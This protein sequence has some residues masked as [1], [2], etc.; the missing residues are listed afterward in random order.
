VALVLV[1]GVLGS[2]VAPG[3][4]A[5]AP[6]ARPTAP[7]ALGWSPLDALGDLLDWL[8]LRGPAATTASSGAPLESG[9]R[10][11]FGF[12]RGNALTQMTGT[13]GLE[14][15]TPTATP[16][17]SLSPG[18]TPQGTATA[19]PEGTAS[20]TPLTIGT[21][22]NPASQIYP[23][24]G[25]LVHGR[26]ELGQLI[27]LT[28]Q[29]TTTPGAT[30]MA[31]GVAARS[32][33]AD[34]CLPN[35]S[36]GVVEDRGSRKVTVQAN[37]AGNQIRS[38]Y[39]LRQRPETGPNPNEQ[40]RNAYVSFTDQ[41]V[42]TQVAPTTYVLNP[43]VAALTFWY[44]AV[45]DQQATDIPLEV[46]DNC[47]IWSSFVGA[48][49]GAQLSCLP[50]ETAPTDTQRNPPYVNGASVG[51]VHTLTGSFT[52]GDTDVSIAGR[53]P[54]PQFTRTYNSNDPRPGAFG[55]G[56]THN[57]AIH[58]ARPTDATLDLILVGPQGR[59]D[60]YVRQ[61]NGTYTRPPAVY[62]QLAANADGTYTAT[63]KDQTT[64]HFNRCGRLDSI[65]DRYLNT[66]NLGYDAAGLL[67][68]IG[69]P[70][71]R[72]SL[73]LNY[74]GNSQ[75]VSVADWLASGARTVGY[76]YD[77][78]RRLLSVT[79]RENATTTFAYDGT[80]ARLTT[81]TNANSHVVA[82]NTYDSSGRVTAQEPALPPGWPVGQPNPRRSSFSYTRSDG[83]DV[84]LPNSSWQPNAT[85][86]PTIK[87]YYS[88]GWHVTRETR[89]S[90]TETHTTHYEYDANGNRVT[91][92]DPRSQITR[93]CYDGNGNVTARIQPKP[94][95]GKEPPVT[96]N[97][98]DAY[99]NL[100][101]EFPPLAVITT[102]DQI[103][104]CSTAPNLSINANYATV[105]SYLNLSGT[106]EPLR[107]R[108]RKVQQAYTEQVDLTPVG[109]VTTI[110][111][112]E[113]NASGQIT[114]E[115]PPRGSADPDPS[116]FATVHEYYEAGEDATQR[117]MRKRTTAPLT[118]AVNFTY[119]NVGRLKQKTDGNS[120]TWQYEYDKEDRPTI[121][122]S[123]AVPLNG[124]P[125]A[126]VTEQRYDAAGNRTM[127]I[128][129]RG[130]ITRNLYDERELLVEVRQ[131]P[132]NGVDPN[133]DPAAVR[134]RYAYDLLGNREWIMRTGGY[135]A[136]DHIDGATRYLYDAAGRLRQEQQFPN[137]PTQ[138]PLLQQALV[139][140]Y[141]YDANGNRISKQKPVQY[142][143]AGGGTTPSINYSYDLLN[144]LTNIDYTNGTAL[145]VDYVYDRGSRRTRMNSKNDAGTVLQQTKY[146][147]DERGRLICV[148]FSG[149]CLLTTGTRVYYRYDADGHR[150]RL[151]YPN[152]SVVT[153]DFDKAGRLE[154]IRDLG[155]G[156]PVVVYAY[157]ST[158][159]RLEEVTHP[160]GTKQ[161]RVYDAAGR[162][163][164]LRNYILVSGTT[165]TQDSYR[166]LDGLGNPITVDV[167]TMEGFGSQFETQGYAYDGLNRLTY[168][169][170]TTF[171]EL[172]YTFNAAHNRSSLAVGAPTPVPYS[173][174]K[175]DRIETGPAGSYDVDDNG[176]AFSR[177]AGGQVFD[178]A[179][180]LTQ[181]STNLGHADYT[182]DGDGRRIKKEWH[183][184]SGSAVT[185]NYVDDV[186][187]KL[188]VLLDDGTRRYVHGLGVAYS[189]SLTGSA[190][191]Q[192]Y[193][194]DARGSVRAVTANAS[195]LEV[196]RFDPYGNH[197]TLT[198]PGWVAHPFGYTGHQADPEAQFVYMRAR[199]YDPQIGRFLS[200]DTEMGDTSN[201]VSLNR[202]TYALDNPASFTDPS[203][204]SPLADEPITPTWFLRLGLGLGGAAAIQQ[205]AQQ[206]IDRISPYFVRFSQRGLSAVYRERNHP[207]FGWD[208]DSLAVAIRSA[209]A[210]LTP[211]ARRAVYEPIDVFLH[212]PPGA[213]T[214]LAVTYDNRRLAMFQ[215]A[216]MDISYR[217]H[218]S[219]EAL[220][221]FY[222]SR[223]RIL[224][225]HLDWTPEWG[226][227]EYWGIDITMRYGGRSTGFVP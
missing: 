200:R 81:I 136:D 154:G 24:K 45:V 40:F 134:S 189:V 211:A 179:D 112:S 29:A 94:A 44:S 127:T 153:Y 101:A 90:T 199:W 172:H 197:V 93:Y 167:S 215:R 205:A 178:Q 35:V 31:A 61:A 203:G 110:A 66:S 182:Y 160:D 194:T 204:H 25:Y 59:S 6:G 34:G 109:G 46:T 106:P 74:N 169:G 87:D 170:D 1:A 23:S 102:A 166:T 174:D 11:H 15:T 116:A 98:Y 113:Y 164:Q 63:S 105:Y 156:N 217:L 10:P 32:A 126:L 75:L 183:P 141:G 79:D 219:L 53:G 159:G 188:P 151:K 207:L 99:N 17:P 163:T 48:G 181:A 161:H 198:N 212:R 223:G 221:E 4:A 158:D 218:S 72:G 60:R 85:P 124:T 89:P 56:W 115:I 209:G 173:Y 86:A 184:N 73:A 52:A 2:V 193:H 69:D 125:T 43:S 132:Q 213:E 16:S 80:T 195:V 118:N 177:P 51:G 76:G 41:A 50:V 78:S 30:G 54:T 130:Q 14:S 206:G 49:A 139:T 21:P 214:T 71:G 133:K 58:L 108:V 122:R 165:I 22:G 157:R 68:T 150:T 208:I 70:A 210:G 64:W 12:S 225:N 224:A 171:G 26:I 37:G 103:V 97:Q 149:D 57:Y 55:L 162:L 5:S 18:G 145:D 96:I 187:G 9:P 196:T 155:A 92:Q 7:A 220:E 104:D 176:V 88:G 147:Y 123:P 168:Y 39:F 121:S 100:T 186:S 152:G 140:T 107:P 82:K 202:Y 185:T 138:Q 180:R 191:V 128:D 65:T 95:T 33:L 20:P 111:I 216:G 84:T 142:K 190:N 36:I 28:P 137:W 83:V 120:Q 135:P 201:P 119:D 227:W 8:G 175:A 131:A 42:S 13:P 144:R 146:E 114:R 3:T 226:P 222:A 129:G 91:V 38:V 192:V 27:G 67:R 117:G 19:S 148:S 143:S 62:T 47:G 77:T